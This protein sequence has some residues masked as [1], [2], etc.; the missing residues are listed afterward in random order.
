MENI[1]EYIKPELLVLIPVLYFIGMAIKKSAIADKLIP[2]LLGGAGVVLCGI[3]VFANCTFANTADILTAVFT[4]IT[5]GVLIA[6]ASVYVDQ[7]IKQTKKDES[8]ANE[9]G[10]I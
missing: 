8:G 10:T 3:W 9:D 1:S 5:Q 6:G 4:A 7:L 2:W